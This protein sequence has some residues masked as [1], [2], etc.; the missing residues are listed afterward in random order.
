MDN[1]I[2]NKIESMAISNDNKLGRY[3]TL[4]DLI[5]KWLYVTL[6]A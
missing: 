3:N 2:K 5:I 6:L 1:T 4:E